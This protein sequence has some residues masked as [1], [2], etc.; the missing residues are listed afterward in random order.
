MRLGEYTKAMHDVIAE[1]A[2]QSR[3]RTFAAGGFRGGWEV[4]MQCQTFCE[5][6]QN[7]RYRCVREAQYPGLPTL[8]CDFLTER[9][10]GDPPRLWAELKVQLA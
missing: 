1:P 10:D 3:M 9:A 8:K 7:A 5:I 2:N 6:P 4:W